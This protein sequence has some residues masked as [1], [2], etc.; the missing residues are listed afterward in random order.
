MIK[1]NGFPDVNVISL[2]EHPERLQSVIKKFND[3]Q[4]YRIRSHRYKK[5]EEGDCIITGEYVDK[6]PNSTKGAVTSHLKTI[7]WWYEKTKEETGFFCE[8]DISLDTLKYWNFEW[9][10][11]Y[12]KLPKNFGAIQL[13]LI[14]EQEFG[15]SDL[16]F[17]KRNWNDWSACAYL[18]TRSFA[19]KLLDVYYK[20]DVFT[21]D[22]LGIDIHKRKI[23]CF[24]YTLLPVSE[25]ILFSLLEPVYVAP[26]FLE[27]VKNFSTLSSEYTSLVNENNT[28]QGLGHHNSYNVVLDW[29]KSGGLSLESMKN[30]DDTFT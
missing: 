2:K 18:L 6:I 14:K 9:Q 23:P 26:L 15:L 25:N 12:N 8:D 16:Y 13:V 24:E 4:F 27:D 17:R 1:L 30:V 21:L 5:Y 7:K 22:Y 19:K 28:L 11:F 10:E 3:E 29:W 20:N